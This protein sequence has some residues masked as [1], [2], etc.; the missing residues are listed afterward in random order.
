MDNKYVYGRCGRDRGGWLP[1]GPGGQGM[2]Q[3]RA[4]ALARHVLRTRRDRARSLTRAGANAITDV[5]PSRVEFTGFARTARASRQL[6][7]AHIC[8]ARARVTVSRLVRVRG[9]STPRVL[10]C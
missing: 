3:L 1:C 2:A 5:F 8:L 7:A 9:V 6:F 4:G 10:T